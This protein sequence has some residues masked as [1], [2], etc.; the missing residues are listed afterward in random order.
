MDNGVYYNPT[1]ILFG[2]DMEKQIG[3]E[4]APFA[5]RVLLV[6]GQN[7]AEQAG[8][9]DRVRQ[10]L[11]DAGVEFVEL[12]G[13]RPNPAL[14]TVWAGI[15]LARQEAVSLILAV[16]GGS[17]IDTAKAIAAGT[18]NS[19]DIWEY[20][21]GS[22]TPAA[23]LPVAVV[24]TIAGSGSESSNSM[25]I[26]HDETDETR[27]YQDDRLRPVAAVL[28]PEVTYSLPAFNTACGI[29]DASCHVLEKYFTNTTDADITDRL[30]E[31]VL[32]TLLETAPRAIERPNDYAARSNLMWAA[33]VAHDGTL[34]VG[35][36]R[37]TAA[38]TIA[39]ELTSRF[40]I[41]NG[42]AMAVLFPA[43]LAYVAD[44][45]P[46]RF[47]LFASRMMGADFPPEE[48]A[49]HVVD[50]VRQHFS[51]LGLP[52]AMQDLGV[53]Q[54]HFAEIA[55][56]VAKKNGGQIGTYVPIGEKGILEILNLAAEG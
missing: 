56:A 24:L 45:D 55:A 26:R 1:K 18:P 52:Q 53:D 27:T 5:Q 51:R 4:V 6:S 25:V 28:N 20:F 21:E 48:A 29:A 41:T 31:A 46:K 3:E 11:T 22:R 42:A 16:G 37:D 47:Q 12:P 43:W 15:R 9:L 49:A 23:V 2:K 7:R 32:R 8:L 13:V 35:R 14:S 17:V 34:H 40:G 44:H 19:D 10:S 54:E 36:E 30:C 38:R 33:K 39:H 50:Y